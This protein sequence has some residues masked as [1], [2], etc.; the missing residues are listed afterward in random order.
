MDRNDRGRSY[1]FDL[2]RF[3][4]IISSPCHVIMSDNCLQVVGVRAYGAMITY[5]EGRL[6]WN[7]CGAMFT[8]VKTRDAVFRF[9]FSLGSFYFNVCFLFLN[10]L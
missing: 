1:C 6:I 5:L 8:T 2:C 3:I 9:G 4:I 7:R 10:R